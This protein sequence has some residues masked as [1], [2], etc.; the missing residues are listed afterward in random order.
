MLSLSRDTANTTGFVLAHEV[1]H[2]LGSVIWILS[3]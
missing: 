2:Y 3:S 1:G